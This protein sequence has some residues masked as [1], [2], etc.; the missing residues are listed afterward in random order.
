MKPPILTLRISR[1]AIGAAVLTGERLV[2]M[3]GR[4]LTSQRE[5]AFVTAA[6]YVDRLLQLS[7]AHSVVLDAPQ[8]DAATSD[9]L[10][11]VIESVLRDRQITSLI[12]GR[13]DLLRAYGVRAL[14]NRA[15]LREIAH[16]FWPE[17]GRHAGKVRP[18]I[19]DA[20]VAAL[21]AESRLVLNPIPT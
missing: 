4:H 11:A 9:R 16:T 14:R 5:R 20:A 3:D 8:P 12:V 2:L 18:Y 10:V 21:Y 19:A 17:L 15:A 13:S 6:R 1:R 7:K